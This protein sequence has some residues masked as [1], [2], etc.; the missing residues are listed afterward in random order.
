MRWRWTSILPRSSFCPRHR[1]EFAEISFCPRRPSPVWMLATRDH[2]VMVSVVQAARHQAEES[3]TA[4]LVGVR[5]GR[6]HHHRGAV[7]DLR[8]LEPPTLDAV[9]HGRVGQDHATDRVADRPHTRHVEAQAPVH[10]RAAHVRHENH[11]AHIDEMAPQRVDI[12]LRPVGRR[13]RLENTDDLLD[14]REGGLPDQRG[15]HA[16]V[17]LMGHVVRVHSFVGGLGPS[18]V[19]SS[20]LS[21]RDGGNET[22]GE[23]E[24]TDHRILL[25]F[26]CSCHAGNPMATAPA[27]R[28]RAEPATPL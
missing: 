8:R 21:E 10:R 20:R 16:R 5:G 22:G 28:E 17:T 15:N 1:F 3:E 12:D 23:A 27:A 24:G 19:I 6:A 13:I 14:G 7:L 9:H 2:Q 4:Q 26:A 11:I 18:S 25:R